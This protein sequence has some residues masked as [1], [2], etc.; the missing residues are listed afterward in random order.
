MKVINPL[1]LNQ[2]TRV[3]EY[4]NKYFFTVSLS[5]GINLPSGAT[6]LGFDC[7]KDAI[8]CM[9]DSPVPDMG[10]PKPRGEYLVS[11][12]FHS[13]GGKEVT[14]G[15]VT[16]QIGGV[17]KGL[18]VSGPRQWRHGMS[19]P[20]ATITSLPIDY[21]YAYGGEG[22]TKNPDGIGYK[23]D[24][25]P[26]I[27][28]PTETV[29]SPKDRPKPAGLSPLNPIWPQ[30]M[31]FQGN[32]DK[33]YLKEYFPGYPED[34]DWHYFMC[35]PEDQWIEGFFRGDEPFEIHNM[36]PEIAT[37]K[38]NLP[39]LV[40]RCF[41]QH[42]L[43]SVA[44]E[45]AELP[46][47]LD[48]VWFFPEKQ[49][50]LL[51]WR[52]VMEVTDDEAEEVTHV[53]AAYEARSQTPRTY[54]Y[55]R[56]AL[57]K[58]ING[59]DALLN[60]FNTEDLIPAGAMC[61]ME[62]LQER[63]FADG[64]QSPMAENIDAKAASVK[65]MADEKIEEVIQQTEK[66][67]ADTD[68]EIPDEF[69]DKIPDEAKDFIPGQ[70]K[71]DLRKLMDTGKDAKPDPDVEAL[72]RK[73]E[74]IMPGITAG[75]PKKL[76]L[77]NFSFDKIGQIMDTVG[78]FTAKK[79]KEA[80]DLAKSEIEKAKGQLK[81][82]LDSAKK[83]MAQTAGEIESVSD[84]HMAKFK[85]AEEK[86][87]ASFKTLDDIDMEKPPPAPLPR[88]DAEEVGGQLSQVSPQM[89][90]AMQHVQA[91]QA[92]GGNFLGGHLKEKGV[93]D[94]VRDI[95][96]KMR[97]MMES[98]EEELQAGLREAE[99]AFKETYIMG[100]HFMGD[101]LSPHKEPEDAV[102]RRLLDA[103]AAGEDVSG[104]DW[105][106]IDLSGQNLDGVDLSGAFLEQV[107]FKG[108]SLKQ[109]DLSGAI[110]A[111]A[112][113]EDADLSGADLEAANVGA[114]HALR[115]NFSG[116]V[117]KS[118]KLSKGVFSD[119]DF[120]GCNLEDVESLEVGLNGANFAEAHMPGMK[121]IESD[122]EGTCFRDNEMTTTVFYNCTL[123]NVDF[124]GA[125]M[126]R[127][128][129]A[130]VRLSNVLFD[131]A[132]LSSTCFV[133]TDPEKTGMDRVS[134]SRARLDKCN[135]QG[136][137]MQQA[138]FSGASLEN[139]NFA[140]VDLSGANLSGA[141]ARHAQFRKANLTA[142]RLDR[143]NLVEGSLAKAIIVNTSFAGANLH[144]VDF[145]RAI[146]EDSDFEGSNLD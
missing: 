113:L 132:D 51:I 85:E 71:L 128:V 130:D 13:P 50:A 135:F 65:K 72:N 92:A 74:G 35:A 42:Q 102:A 115:A 112:N 66:Q 53:L 8:V 7:L 32:Y 38:G 46:L 30:R 140:K 31:R 108:A 143:I 100:A 48:T 119:A 142:A 76:A 134:F 87:E 133:S 61:A 23:D 6:I 95:E 110:L 69:K 11:G 124:S 88:L 63:A 127:C 125:E 59:G 94:T 139:A 78:D 26:C 98:Q 86:L 96:Q 145:L 109:A 47:S 80:K 9:G 28:N 122:L 39:G 27:E 56:D 70:G 24:R 79:E 99:T 17:E 58:R 138:D 10:M 18:N 126:G 117:L 55:Y 146:I 34:F 105:A 118:A 67:M 22:Y 103:I 2:N 144:G 107:D 21:K 36:H 14:F 49:L 75:D 41:I 101:G 131:R 12:T 1:Q 54:E 45:F 25:L 106:C 77:K 90:E 111:R 141:H 33:N 97:E 52:G 40:P 37:I 29:V 44:P 15:R 104:G 62:I 3:L 82:Q 57:E 114:V 123:N 43:N 4:N 83:N 93:D 20:T 137:V 84:G 120:S 121:F 19:Y 60:N 136:L 116:A 16:V 91:A 89:M 5:L 73:L 64:E 129:F 68:L 81:E